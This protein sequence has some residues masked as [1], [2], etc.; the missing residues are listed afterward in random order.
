M[1]RPTIK[2]VAR[3]AECSVS[4]VSIVVNGRGYVSEET[5]G[6]VM[7]VVKALGYHA[8][9]SARGLASKTS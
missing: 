7:G 3:E 1:K 6:R 2:D 5:R 4:T 8:T 9:R